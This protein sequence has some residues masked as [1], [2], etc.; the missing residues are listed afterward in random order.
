MKIKKF[1]ELFENADLFGSR[2]KHEKIPLDG[3]KYSFHWLTEGNLFGQIYGHD[4][5]NHDEFILRKN[6]G[7]K[8]IMPPLP[9]TKWCL[10]GDNSD[11]GLCMTVDPGYESAGISGE[12]K[13]CIVFD[14]PKLLKDFKC[15][16]L[17]DNGE[18]EI[19]FQK[20]SDWYKYAIGL[21]S[22]KKTY[23]K[24]DGW[25]GFFYRGIHEWLPEELKKIVHV[26]P[27]T[28]SICKELKKL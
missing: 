21:Y 5:K 10:G 20:I 3:V 4:I 11:Y 16:D 17:T 22:D 7:K 8:M 13:I 25:E 23:E 24:G 27:S 15:K 26:C 9:P 6:N 14:L 19:R 12:S 2:Q 18:A 1:S 28:I